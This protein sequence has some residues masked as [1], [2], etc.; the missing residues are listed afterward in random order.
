[1]QIDERKRLL[2]IA[3][4]YGARSYDDPFRH[5]EASNMEH[6]VDALVSNAVALYKPAAVLRPNPS[7]TRNEFETVVSK[8]LG[9]RVGDGMLEV[10][11][12]RTYKNEHIQFLWRCYSFKGSR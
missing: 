3:D 12:A 6:L 7:T 2:A 10:T 5:V 11:E 8:L 4:S 1:M 9:C